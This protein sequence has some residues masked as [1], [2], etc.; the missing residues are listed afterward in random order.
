MVRQAELRTHGG[1]IE[2]EDKHMKTRGSLEADIIIANAPDPVF[3][4][5]SHWTHRTMVNCTTTLLVAAGL[6]VA[7]DRQTEPSAS[8]D[9][10]ARMQFDVATLGTADD[11]TLPSPSAVLQRDVYDLTDELSVPVIASDPPPSSN[12][13]LL[14]GYEASFGFARIL[15]YNIAPFAPGPDCVPDAAA[16]G[17]TGNGRGVAYDPLDGNLWITRLTGFAGDGL[18]HKVTPPQVTPG[19]CPQVDVIPF[20][21]GPGGLI[22]D[23]IGALD[24]DQGSKH[25]WAAGYAP[26]SVGGGPLR[27]YFYLVDRNN[28]KILQS[29]YIPANVLNGLGFNDSE[30]YARL[31]GLPGSGQYLMTDGGEF[32]EGSSLEVIDTAGCHDGKEATV[33]ATFLTTHGLTGIDFEWP[34]L[35]STDAFFNIYNDGNQPF[36]SSTV[37]G[38]AN[39]TFGLEDIS[40]CGFRAKLGG[41]GNDGCRY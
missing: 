12:S 31:P 36:T 13:T 9:P 41:D 7:C 18:I 11:P 29:C 2:G 24:L 23:D 1:V 10:S 40:L 26:I 22:Q 21:D 39:A 30:T 14:W 3:V 33:V 8:A 25:I 35:L 28:G 17:P 15:S 20:G 19:I 37:I 6:L 5:D 34:G 4:S 27:N 32:F 16:G 38:P